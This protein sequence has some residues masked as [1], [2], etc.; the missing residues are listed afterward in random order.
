[1]RK[2]RIILCFEAGRAVE[3]I[4]TP[5]VAKIK[6]RAALEAARLGSLSVVARLAAGEILQRGF[7]DVGHLH[8]Q[9]ARGMA[10]LN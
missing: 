5:G 1:M 10:G 9:A 4:S 6:K 7:A 2:Q 3:E 8:G